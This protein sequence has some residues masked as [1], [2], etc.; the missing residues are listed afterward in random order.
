MS[1]ETSE[2]SVAGAAYGVLAALIWGGF[3]AIT[4]LSMANH[5]LDAWDV[6]ALRF[7]TAGLLTLP[8]FVRHGLGALRWPGAVLLAVGAGA[9]YV[10]LTA[11]GLAFAPA[12]HMGVITP[13]CMLLVSTVGSWAL[14]G[15]KLDTGGVA[16]VLT[17]VAGILMLGWDGLSSPGSNVLLGDA[18]FVLGG[19]FWASYTLATRAWGVPPLQATVVVA[20]L[21]MLGYVPFY[22]AIAGSH[23][24]AAPWKEIAIQAVFQ[25]ALSAV[26]ALVFYTRS[27]AL[28]GAARGAV[29]GALVPSLSLLFAIPILGEIPTHLQIVGVGVVT[30]GM[31]LVL[32][33][34]HPARW[35]RAPQ[36]LG[37]LCV[38]L[39]SPAFAQRPSI[40]PQTIAG[41]ELK[42]TVVAQRDAIQWPAG[43]EVD[44]LA[45]AAIDSRG[46]LFLLNRGKEAVLEFDERGAFVRSFG[47]GLFQRVHSITLD[48][49]GHFWI[50]DVAA[51]AVLEL[52]AKGAV[53]RTLGTSGKAGDWDEAAGTRLFNEPTDVAFARD[54]SFFVTQGHTRGEPKVLKF[55]ADGRF[56][57]QWGGR[58]ALPWQFEVAHSI[59][60]DS[61]G[62]LYVADRENRRIV[63]FDQNGEFV[64]GWVYRGLVC[65]LA[66]GS[67]GALYMT[68]GFDGQIAKLDANGRVL[69]VTGHS[70]EGPNEYGEAHDLAVARDGAIFVTD[71]V[72]KRLTKLIPAR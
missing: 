40:P 12:A 46:H 48:S 52:D 65:S 41:P 33:L 13:S 18:M 30:A 34:Y 55:D 70:G 7:A 44:Q 20:M 38:L 45:S 39:G 3:P 32:G 10:L 24:A 71:V 2:S 53:V 61:A 11:G 54:G 36:A 60:I 22:A 63:V 5:T 21:S 26:V 25:G 57:K 29:F 47:A 6:T 16:G 8:L 72:D 15:G 23:L 67:D 31:L 9:P 4:K 1:A 66:F 35:R 58:G 59:A 27:V 51:H 28:L 14:L 56:V 69:G 43:I 62:L 49:R 68:S 19:V 17:I 42:V 37:L 50:T 64:K